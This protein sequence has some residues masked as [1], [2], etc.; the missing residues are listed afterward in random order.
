MN[1]KDAELR[2]ALDKL[3]ERLSK[4]LDSVDELRSLL[5]LE[6]PRFESGQAKFSAAATPD[7][8]L[9][10]LGPV[11]EKIKERRAENEIEGNAE[12]GSSLSRG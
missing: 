6:E 4:A 7:G 9:S 8:A 5:K 2:Q 3:E 12:N 11:A 1:E 10:I